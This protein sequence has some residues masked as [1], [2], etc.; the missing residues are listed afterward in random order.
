MGGWDGDDLDM[1]TFFGWVLFVMLTIFNLII[2][3]NFVIAIITEVYMNVR[4]KQVQSTYEEKA[5]LILDVI[6]NPLINPFRSSIFGASE[7]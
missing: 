7:N 5:K 2:L 4:D 3:L 6:E 1:L